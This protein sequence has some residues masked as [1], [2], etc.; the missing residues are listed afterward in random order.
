MKRYDQEET[1][2]KFEPLGELLNK[3]IETHTVVLHRGASGSVEVNYIQPDFKENRFILSDKV[4]GK[5]L[6]SSAIIIP[7]PCFVTILNGTM[8]LERVSENLKYKASISL[9]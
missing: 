8:I 4:E 2:M 7:A 9:K 5:R 3:L 6:S 1:I